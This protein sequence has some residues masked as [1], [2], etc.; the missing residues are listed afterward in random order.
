MRAPGQLSFSSFRTT[1]I[2]VLLALPLVACTRT[3]QSTT[4][5]PAP[6]TTASDTRATETKP[7]SSRNPTAALASGLAE[8]PSSKGVDEE[9]DALVQELR[10]LP[11]DAPVRVCTPCNLPSKVGA[12]RRREIYDQF[13]ALG[14]TAVPALARMLKGSLR[15]SDRD[16]TNTI[17]W[18]LSNVSSPYIS[19]DGRQPEKNDISAALPALILALDDP[20]EGSHAAS[21]IGAIGPKATEV[22]PRL[23]AM[24]D[25]ENVGVR[26]GACWG[27]KGIDPLPALRQARS[28][29]NPDKQRFAQ[30]AIASIETKCLARDKSGTT[31][32]EL[33]RTADLICKATVIADRS[34]IDDSFK[35]IDG[36]EVRE[37]ELRVIS[38]LKGEP[39]NVIRFRYYGRPQN[40][41]ESALIT[42]LRVEDHY[43]SHIA[44]AE[45]YPFASG[46]TYLV[47]ATQIAGGTYREMAAFLPSSHGAVLVGPPPPY[48]GMISPGVLLAADAKPH[49]GTT[50]TEA[51]WSELLALLKS[52]REDDVLEAIHPLDEMSGGP[53]WKGNGHT[54]FERDEALV[55]IQ[56][57]VRARSADIATAAVT[58]F[59]GDSPYF[60][61]QDVPFWLVGIGKGHITGLGARKRPENPVVAD[62]GA[63]DLLQVATDG[64]TPK[65]R[66]LAIRALGRRPHAYPAAMVAVWARDPSVEVRRAAV[67]ASADVPDREPIMTAS[68]DGSPEL[69]STAAWAVGFAQDLRLLSILDKLLHDPIADVRSAAA[70]SL[71]SFAPDQAA[72][73]MEANLTSDFR[74]LFVNALASR[75]P[76]PYVAMLAEIIEQVQ[77]KVR[78]D[79]M[80]PT[81]WKYG[82]TIPAADSWRILFDFVKSRPAAELTAGKLDR[83]LDALERMHWFSSGEPTELY[84]LYLSRGLVSR[85]KQFR[86]TTRKSAPFD[87]DLF[88]DRVDQNPA[89]YLR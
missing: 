80:E 54:I 6:F 70:L 27:L 42:L 17:L 50:L 67:L 55:A 77:G 74:P 84:A 23:V 71:L 46:R 14:S 10:D 86:D 3:L 43:L 31:L 60:Y 49:R 62:I 18:I 26:A 4:G 66:A 56:P 40:P 64:M 79:Q 65:L 58:V 32:E 29:P 1:S 19:R 22:V 69:R 36:F 88:F 21:I 39:P 30:R 76:Q 82:G 15:S 87:M 35:P 9:V 7:E 44:E 72:P 41:P 63:K 89:G 24:L 73:V 59:G 20:N 2:V 61:D 51:A 13:N 11:G 8:S 78:P 53:A 57:L 37:A 25:D 75:D 83:S 45:R 85:A 28:D 33:A 52:P 48:F 34:V 68:T 38:T 12:V 81:N 5:R 16:L 47:V